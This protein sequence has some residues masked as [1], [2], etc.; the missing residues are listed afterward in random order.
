MSSNVTEK[1][2]KQNWVEIREKFQKYLISEKWMTIKNLVWNICW[3]AWTEP[4]DIALC[5]TRMN[6]IQI[7][8]SSQIDL[9]LPDRLHWFYDFSTKKGWSL[10]ENTICRASPKKSGSAHTAARAL[11]SEW[12]REWVSEHNRHPVLGLLFLSGG[13]WID[14]YFLGMISDNF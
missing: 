3:H 1:H 8:L 11:H 2:F 14:A 10:V 7:K 6:W 4:S 12:H 9:N 5:C 13:F